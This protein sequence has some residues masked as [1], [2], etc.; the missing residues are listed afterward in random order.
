MLCSLVFAVLGKVRFDLIVLDNFLTFFLVAKS[1][2][3]YIFT[4]PAGLVRARQSFALI[5]RRQT[6]LSEN[7]SVCP[8]QQC[9]CASLD[10]REIH[11]SEELFEADKR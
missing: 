8:S 4:G 7:M 6:T 9:G 5:T 2:E 3:L 10:E 1:V 11:V